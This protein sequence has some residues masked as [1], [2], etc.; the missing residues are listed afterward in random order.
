MMVTLYSCALPHF[1]SIQDLESI[2]LTGRILIYNKPA[3][4]NAER[5]IIIAQQ[6]ERYSA[7]KEQYYFKS[8]SVNHALE[9][10]SA[11]FIILRLKC[12]LAHL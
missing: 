10:G 1:S 12:Y 8:V 2:S 6:T 7:W 9:Y 11:A 5:W 3:A 4:L